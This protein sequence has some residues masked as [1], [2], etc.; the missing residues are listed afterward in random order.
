MTL[1]PCTILALPSKVNIYNIKCPGI[2]NK[3]KR[4]GYNLR[5][6][7]KSTVRKVSFFFFFFIKVF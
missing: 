3:Y 7:H 2:I 6:I 4:G 1:G 5:E